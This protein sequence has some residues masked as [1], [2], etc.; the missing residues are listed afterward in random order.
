V[1][2]AGAAQARSRSSDAHGPWKPGGQEE[3]AMADWIPVFAIVAFVV[4]LAVLNLIETRQI[5]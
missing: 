3:L 1:L 4:V 2:A 5:D